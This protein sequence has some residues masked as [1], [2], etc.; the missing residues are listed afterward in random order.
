V[1]GVMFWGCWHRWCAWFQK[2][3]AWLYDENDD[4]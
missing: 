4:G 1:G 3:T 2:A